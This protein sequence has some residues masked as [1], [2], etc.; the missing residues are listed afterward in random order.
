M[1]A[2]TVNTVDEYIAAFPKKMQQLLKQ[3]RETILN[4]AP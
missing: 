1:K 4:A 2:I 3:M